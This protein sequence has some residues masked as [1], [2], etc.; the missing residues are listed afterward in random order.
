MSNLLKAFFYHIPN[1]FCINRHI[2]VIPNQQHAPIINGFPPVLINFT[3]SVFSPIAAIAVTMKNLLKI[4]MGVK[5]SGESP[6]EIQIVVI[7][8]ASI[9]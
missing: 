9:K 7:I 1:N 6:N 4:F 3:I 5:I 8:D 2:A